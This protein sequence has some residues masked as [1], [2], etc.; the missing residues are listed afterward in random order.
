MLLHIYLAMSRAHTPLLDN[1]SRSL[2]EA[3]AEGGLTQKKLGERVGLPQSHISKIEK[4][5]VD[6]QLTSLAELA[7]ALDLEIRLIP[8]SASSAV[9]A[10]IKSVA[11]PLGSA[12]QQPALTLD[13]EDG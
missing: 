2:R 5:G 6:L 4:G 1:I 9:D 13:D 11:A 7:R 10:V 8:R 12:A 3:R